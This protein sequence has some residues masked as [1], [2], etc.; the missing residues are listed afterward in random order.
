[1][2]DS[3]RR[4]FITGTAGGDEDEDGGGDGE[5]Y[6]DLEGGEFE[7]LEDAEGGGGNGDNAKPAP[8]AAAGRAAALAAKKAALKRKFDE[9]YDDPEADKLDFYDEQK[10]EMAAQAAVNA[11]EFAGIDAAAR[12]AVEGLRP[13]TYV[14]LEFTGAPAE[15]VQ[16]FD[17]RFPLLVGGLLPAEERMGVL[18]ARVKRHR[19]H[20][21]T[22]KSNDPLV[23]SLGW[24]RFQ[25]LPLFALDDHSVRMRLLKYT[26]EHMHCF[27]SFYAPVALPNTGFCAFR[28]LGAGAPGFRVAA[29]G[30]VLDVDRGADIVKKLKLTGTPYKVFKNTAFVRDMFTSALEV[31]KFEGAHIR[32]V[33]GIRGQ[34]KK[35]LPKPDGALRATFEDKILMSGACARCAF[36]APR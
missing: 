2:L 21:R 16:H 13:G 20:A 9:Q 3:L 24:R 30:V 17:P 1:V 32:T 7:D 27:A 29:T 35:A 19:W 23:L 14:R 22:L 34:I 15:L 12:A 33:S 25:T 11:A 5:G 31:A 26:P 36:A 6:E 4:L 18:R 10:A 28:A 8:D